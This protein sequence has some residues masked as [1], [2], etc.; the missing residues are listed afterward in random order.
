MEYGKYGIWKSPYY[1]SID[2]SWKMVE[3]QPVKLNFFEKTLIETLKFNKLIQI[4]KFSKN[5]RVEMFGRT[6]LSK[7]V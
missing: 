5:V 1:V 3:K 7:K 2:N 6:F 4:T